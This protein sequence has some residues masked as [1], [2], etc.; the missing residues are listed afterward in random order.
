MSSSKSPAK[1][2]ACVASILRL[3]PRIPSLV[4]QAVKSVAQQLL[5]AECSAEESL[6]AC[7]Y[8]DRFQR[9]ADMSRLNSSM[10]TS[11]CLLRGSA[12]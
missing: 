1:I 9:S 12:L 7:D 6:D 5:S 10:S 2:A 4:Q 11:A 3:V 8:F